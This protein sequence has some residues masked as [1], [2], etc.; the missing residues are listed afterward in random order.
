[1]GPCE[2]VEFGGRSGTAATTDGL[3]IGGDRASGVESACKNLL[4]GCNLPTVDD[5]LP[6]ADGALPTADDGLPTAED[7]GEGIAGRRGLFAWSPFAWKK[8]AAFFCGGFGGGAC[9][10]GDLTELA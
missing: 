8:T 9:S 5:A 3:R 10:L 6:T 4:S 7:G 1:M 2:A